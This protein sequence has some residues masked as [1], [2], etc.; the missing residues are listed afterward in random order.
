MPKKT[1]PQDLVQESKKKMAR[2]QNKKIREQENNFR[3]QIDLYSALQKKY[4]PQ[5]ING[6]WFT[7]NSHSKNYR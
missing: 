1:A 6:D 5:K 4:W 3:N 7:K 2:H